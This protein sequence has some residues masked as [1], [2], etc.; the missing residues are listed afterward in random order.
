MIPPVADR[1]VAGEH[2]AQA[3][4]HAR[5][6]NGRGIGAILNLLGEHYE[7]PEPAAADAATYRRLLDDI[8]RSDLDCCVSVKPSQVGLDIG[9]EAFRE[10]LAEIV[11]TADA[12]GVFVW[13]DMED[14]TT[15]DA[16]LDAFC[17]LVADHHDMGLCLQ[18]NMR[19]TPEDLARLADLPGKVRL[20]KGAYDPPDEVAYRRKERVDEA[21]RELLGQAFRAFDGGVAVGSH[22]PA[23]IDHAR[24]LHE[25]YGTAYEVQM[26]M[27]VREGAQTELAREMPVY[28]YVPYG[29]KWFSYFYRRVKENTGNATFAL[30]AIVSG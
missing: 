23:M 25:Q 28:Q 6:L 1:F 30:R 16:T 8:G 17:D 14:H 29:E 19:R 3:L 7:A 22:D 5:E 24:D 12:R 2:P 10:T 4:E 27:G 18:A 15:V 9:E 11:A 26:L 20:V 21:Y 13:V